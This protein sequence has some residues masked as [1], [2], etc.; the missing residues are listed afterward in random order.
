MQQTA[1]RIFGNVFDNQKLNRP[2]KRLIRSQ[3]IRGWLQ[4]QKWKA[5]LA[6]GQRLVPEED[7]TRMYKQTLTQLAATG[8]Y[9]GDYLEFGVFNGTSLSCMHTA[10]KE[11]GV[12]DMRLFGFDSFEG[13]PESATVDDWDPGSYQMDEAYAR[14][15][16][17]RRG[18]DWDRVFLVKGWFSDT[19]NP[20][21]VARHAISRASVIMVDCDAYESTKEA[22][23]FCGPLIHERAVVFF[24]DWN[25]GD[26]AHKGTGEKKAWEEFIAANPRLTA[27]DIGGYGRTSKV[28]EVTAQS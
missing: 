15:W 5:R 11:V 18:I 4:R 19:L 17:T 25:S 9:L 20:D 1:L 21:L 26:R 6:L 24:D 28:F 23:Q 16:L 22:L 8:D 14:A 10:V 27:R 13:L 2:L 12:R 7:L 3:R